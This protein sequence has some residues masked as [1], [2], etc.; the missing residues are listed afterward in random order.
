[1]WSNSFVNEALEKHKK[2]MIYKYWLIRHFEMDIDINNTILA[3]SELHVKEFTI[4][5]MFNS[6][7]INPYGI[8]F[9]KKSL[10]F[11]KQHNHQEKEVLLIIKDGKIISVD[12]FYISDRT[13]YYSIDF[14]KSE[15]KNITI[16][17]QPYAL[18]CKNGDTCVTT[19]DPVFR[20]Y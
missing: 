20:V 3:L 16:I 2:D 13:H 9:Q 17:K 12:M 14:L 1:M 7:Y 8:V 6:V 18:F 5:E 11:D 19:I 4:P 10:P 15:I